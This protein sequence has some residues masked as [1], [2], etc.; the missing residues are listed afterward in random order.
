MPITYTRGEQ[1]IWTLRDRN[2]DPLSN[3]W[4]WAYRDTQRD[5]FKAI[6]TDPG[7]AVAWDNPIQ[8]DAAG[9]LQNL[10]FSDDGAY[11]FEISKERDGLI[12]VDVVD[13]VEHY[14]PS[15][16]GG[17]GPVTVTKDIKNFVVNPQFT[18]HYPD[19][20]GVQLFPAE[21]ELT[22]AEGG[23]SFRKD[24]GDSTDALKF[25]PFPLGI[26]NPPHNPSVY[27]EYDCT[28]AGT[29]ET[30]KEIV[31]KVPNVRL[32]AAEPIYGTFYAKST[33]DSPLVV[34]IRQF[35]GTGG[36]PSATV[37]TDI[38]DDDLIATWERYGTDVTLP[39]ISGKT[40]GTN[41][42]DYLAIVFK[43]PVNVISNLQLVNIQLETGTT[44]SDFERE[45]RFE[46][47]ERR[48][49]ALLPPITEFDAGKVLAVDRFYN[50]YS[51][52][53]VVSWQGGYVPV[54]FGG[55]W[56]T[57]ETNRIPDGWF[58]CNGD[59]KLRYQYP[60]LLAALFNGTVGGPLWGLKP[61]WSFTSPDTA[62]NPLQ[63]V[64][65]LTATVGEPTIPV[66]TRGTMPG[67][68]II[69]RVQAGSPTL[70][71]IYNLTFPAASALTAGQHW[72][73]STYVA[74]ESEAQYYVWYRINGVG[75]DPAIGGRTGI[76]VDILS[77]DGALAVAN[78]SSNA[79]IDTAFY[80]PDLR[81][82]FVR[83]W[84]DEQPGHPESDNLSTHQHGVTP[85][86]FNN[87]TVGGD[88]SIDFTT[89]FTDAPIS[90]PLQPANVRVAFI[91][92]HD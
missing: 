65:L 8:A 55:M 70:Q 59:T 76:R 79:I 58:L 57:D 5:E 39:S 40:F 30:Y 78:K 77:S 54:G 74:S 50:P 75:V 27:L 31:W 85:I 83:G 6:Y 38:Y 68:F 61:E 72:L 19:K 63:T 11:Y 47:N 33:A 16:T 3:G 12:P 66:T 52:A 37:D 32:F 89:G 29:G 23:W 34:S 1:P 22:I 13:T 62:V 73:T 49:G 36:A 56:F 42:D 86:V 46:Q 14:L 28:A 2:G 80:L 60:F 24:A 17:G 25:I 21:H 91:I 15:G 48:T 84:G 51:T 9:T 43:L 35:F 71:Q 90:P 7:G 20:S 67:G 45:S 44:V 26:T 81:N 41:Y 4:L 10:F 53:P 69:A 18:D 64:T 88:S 82:L 87:N 92:K